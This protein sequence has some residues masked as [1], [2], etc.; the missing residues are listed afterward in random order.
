[1]QSSSNPSP[2]SPY[3]S[4]DD[5]SEARRTSVVDTEGYGNSILDTEQVK[6]YSLRDFGIDVGSDLR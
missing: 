4:Q 2:E 5:E 6:G 1:M 3:I